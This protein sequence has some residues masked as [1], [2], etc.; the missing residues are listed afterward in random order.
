MEGRRAPVARIKALGSYLPAQVL[1]NRDLEQK[2]DTSDEWIVSRTG[3]AERRLA[4]EGEGACE[5][6]VEAA[7]KALQAAGLAA[8][9]VDLILVATMSPDYISPSTATLIQ[10]ALKCERAA[11]FDLQAACSGYLYA[12]ATA[13][14]FVESGMYRCVLVVATEKLSSFVN[15]RDRNTCVLFGDGASAFVVAASGPGLAIKETVLGSDGEQAQLLFI[16]AGG[17]RCP[18]SLAS[19]QAEQHYI[20]MNGKEVFKHAVR[21]MEMAAIECLE[22]AGLSLP[23]IDWLVPHQANIRIIEALAKR[24][25]MSLQRVQQTVHKYGNTSAS[26]LGIALDELCSEGKVQEGQHILLVAFGAGLTWGGA[27]LQRIP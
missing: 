26:S 14:A 5:M 3:I 11:S 6:G 1:S 18:A 23:Q 21:R 13:K 20:A 25:D 4:A 12:L 2:V 10:H 15:Y 9:D 8:G 7:K 24:F 16:P 19:V 17:S 27:I 22:K